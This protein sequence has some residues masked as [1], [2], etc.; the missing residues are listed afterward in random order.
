MLKFVTYSNFFI[1]ASAVMLTFGTCLHL[2]TTEN[3]TPYL[4]LV[5]FATML[6]YNLHRYVKAQLN[7]GQSKKNDWAQRHKTYL[8]LMATA[9]AIGAFT[10]L[11]FLPVSAIL[12]LML[13]AFLTVIYSFP[14]S[15]FK[16]KAFDIRRIPGLKNLL[17]AF[18]WTLVTAYIP[19]RLAATEGHLI[20]L[21]FTLIER[22]VFV[23]AL[24]IPFDLK[25]IEEDQ[26]Q[27][28][29]T[30]PIVLGMTNAKRLSLF[31]VQ[32]YIL[33][34]IIQFILLQEFDQLMVV[35]GTGIATL[36]VLQSKKLSTLELYYPLWVDGTIL[37]YGVLLV[38]FHL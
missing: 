12:W 38:V 36:V 9:S 26:W 34:G 33:I 18:V 2:Q 27:G 28:L 22:F 8:L 25:D 3:L 35:A 13:A 30:L 15:H 7:I 19:T 5:L 37:L 14:F 31:L 23:Y 21:I 16:M 1:A 24:T 11:W 4:L 29:R 6:D 20:Q 32:I 10:M 17:I